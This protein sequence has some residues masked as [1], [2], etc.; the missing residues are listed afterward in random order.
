MP[1]EMRV[2]SVKV[3]LAQE[4]PEAGPRRRNTFDVS[5]FV[6]LLAGSVRFPVKPFARLTCTACRKL[7]LP[8]GSGGMP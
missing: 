4:L 2:P 5:L 1:I 8:V 3:V 7:A 6:A